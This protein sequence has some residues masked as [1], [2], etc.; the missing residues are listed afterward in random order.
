MSIKSI[1]AKSPDDKKPFKAFWCPHSLVSELTPPQEEKGEVSLRC[2][3]GS[4]RPFLPVEAAVGGTLAKE[5]E[6][7]H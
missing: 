6:K 4:L 1:A 7:V 2:G 3:A 5:A